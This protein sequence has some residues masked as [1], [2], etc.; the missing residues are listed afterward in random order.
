MRPFAPN[1]ETPLFLFSVDVE[2]PARDAGDGAAS[3]QRVAEATGSILD[4]LAKHAATGTFFVTG[5]VA[6]ALPGLVRRIAEGGHEIACHSDVHTRLERLGPAGFR[7]DCLNAL[8]ALRAAGA[9]RVRGYRAPC[10][11]L[12]AATPWAHPILAELG[13]DYSSSVLPAHNPISGWRG[14]GTGPA[15]AGNLVELPVTLLANRLLPVPCGGVYFR[16]LPRALVL[17][18][19]RGH[20]R[21]GGPVLAYLHPYD[22]DH[23]QPRFAHPGFSR[24]GLYNRLMFRGR[25]DVLPRLEQIARMGFRFAPYGPYAEAARLALAAEAG[26]E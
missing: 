12:T 18:A 2:D 23:D 1:K 25:G 10:F 24:H 8:A 22:V 7:E 13:F 14:F 17:R 5:E 20:A 16:A 19:L 26:I 3:K 4:F 15:M 9:D 6:R 11:S 21:Q